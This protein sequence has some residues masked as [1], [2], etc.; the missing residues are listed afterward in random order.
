MICTR[1]SVAMLAILLGG[2]FGAAPD[3]D[4]DDGD[5]SP[6]STS[7]TGPSTST[8]GVDTLSTSGEATSADTTSTASDPTGETAGTSDSGDVSCVDGGSVDDPQCG[9]AMFEPGELCH[10][11]SVLMVATQGTDITVIP[12]GDGPADLVVPNADGRG[13]GLSYLSNDGAG[14]FTPMAIDGVPAAFSVRAAQLDA[15]GALDLVVGLPIGTRALLGQ[16]DGDFE[17]VAG[18]LANEGSRTRVGFAQLDDNEAIDVV[19]VGS[20]L[21]DWYTHLGIGAGTFMNGESGS[22]TDVNKFFG[23]ASDLLV[24]H[25]G[26]FDED[27]I[28]VVVASGYV[29][30]IPLTGN[31]NPDVL[32]DPDGMGA[33]ALSLAA[34]D[35]DDDGRSDL[36]SAHGDR[37]RVYLGGVDDYG[38]PYDIP[39]DPGAVHV[40]IVDIDRDG[41]RDLVT[42]GR[43]PHRVVV[44]RDVLP[45][46]NFDPKPFDLPL[47]AASGPL[48]LV[49]AP[50]DDDCVPDV[51]VAH[52]M[53]EVSILLSEP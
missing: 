29:A 25:F 14:T 30:R 32:L 6:T 42:L 15:G 31:A 27:V 38:S 21:V 39:V 7:T 19:R 18:P 12:I 43:N 5:D 23:G 33:D 48:R 8:S 49:V 4:D 44:V 22:L 45:G 16:G 11:A 20:D 50:L 41:H 52:E 10:S 3:V 26:A 1:S 35:L 2:C 37:L 46:P 36:V 24:G 40:E 34:G 9:N 28:A 53:G 17:L 47:G 51:A 13:P